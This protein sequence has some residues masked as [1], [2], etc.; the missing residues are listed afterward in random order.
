MY[1]VVGSD[2]RA[3]NFIK[4]ELTFVLMCDKSFVLRE[5]RL[6]FLAVQPVAT[7]RQ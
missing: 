6:L 5:G 3:S 2:G 4:I 7:L 1:V